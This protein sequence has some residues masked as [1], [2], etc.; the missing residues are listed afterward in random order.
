MDHMKPYYIPVSIS[1]PSGNQAQTMKCSGMGSTIEMG[2][3]KAS[4]VYP[5]RSVWFA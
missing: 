3:Q 4:E 5:N 2:Y 1:G